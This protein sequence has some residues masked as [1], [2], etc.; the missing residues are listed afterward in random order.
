MKFFLLRV[1]SVLVLPGGA[2]ADSFTPLGYLPNGYDSTA[3]GVSDD[4]SVVVGQSNQRAFRWTSAGGME[5]IG[6]AYGSTALGVS[7]D[8]NVIVGSN[9]T[10][11]GNDAFRWD[12]A[13]GIVSLGILPGGTNF[14]SYAYGASGDGSVI[15]GRAVR[16]IYEA[17]RWTSATGTVGLGGL[18]G[19]PTGSEAL[20]I[21]AD[22]SV[23]VGTSNAPSGVESFRWTAATGMTSLG[24]LPGHLGFEVSRAWG[25]SSDGSII[26]GEALNASNAAEAYRWTSQTGMVGLGFLPGGSSSVA[27]DVSADGSIVVGRAEGLDSYGNLAG[28][29][30][31]WTPETGMKG[32]LE[33]LVGRGV[34]GLDGWSLLEATAV[35][36]DGRWVVGLGQN[37]QYLTEGFIVELTPIP[38]PP[39]AW[40]F[41]SALG[42]IGATRRRLVG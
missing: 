7:A 14:L 9:P 21:S 36:A 29:A 10:S 37:P 25:I 20:A 17:T 35:S 31:V 8:G 24:H 32:L 19:P 18:S 3:R 34:T 13:A 39:A 22:G 4:G 26:V 42:V 23:L 38:V 2:I 12:S 41:G 28:L 33:L 1:L 5:T 16:N 6:G 11:S 15:A 40:L 27:R 30:F